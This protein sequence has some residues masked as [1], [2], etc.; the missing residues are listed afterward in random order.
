MRA[1][2]HLPFQQK[3]A[4]LGKP[5]RDVMESIQSNTVPRNLPVDWFKDAN[6]KILSAFWAG[7]SELAIAVTVRGDK[8]RA[9]RENLVSHVVVS[10]QEH[11]LMDP[12]SSLNVLASM[13]SDSQ[14]ATPE[15]LLRVLG[16]SNSIVKDD[17][18]WNSW[19][20]RIRGFD[21]VFLKNALG[22]VANRPYTYL[23]YSEED[24]L[25][26]LLR[27]IFMII[28][29]FMGRKCSFVSLFGTFDEPDSFVIR[30]FR[31]ESNKLDL[32]TDELDSIKDQN[33]SLIDLQDEKILE[34]REKK[35]LPEVLLNELYND[36]WVRLG[37]YEHL[38]IL[39][40]ILQKKAAGNEKDLHPYS[41]QLLETL[42]RLKRID[43]ESMH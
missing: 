42:R 40:Y 1:Y 28:Q 33:A 9:G 31:K 17:D 5:G 16:A 4:V 22:T 43:K 37:R 18:G 26:D 15:G 2:I 20:K 27:V 30:A 8:D 19:I 29:P 12:L 36:P 21:Q 10:D 32:A 34:N 6:L 23:A 41:E 39:R 7:E 11:F 14:I 24:R 38:S 3:P 25:F 13:Y 35:K